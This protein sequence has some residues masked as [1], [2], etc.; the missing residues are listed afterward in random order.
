[1]IEIESTELLLGKIEQ[2][3][4]ANL[5]EDYFCFLPLIANEDWI[6]M[7]IPVIKKRI[8][9]VNICIYMRLI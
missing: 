1:M 9:D 4:K 8:F 6:K 3:V 2:Y 7:K 5:G